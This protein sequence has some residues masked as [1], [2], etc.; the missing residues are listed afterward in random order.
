MK[1]LPLPFP[2]EVCEISLTK[3][4]TAIVSAEDYEWCLQ[5]KWMASDHNGLDYACRGMRNNGENRKIRLHRAIMER[6]VGRPLTP[7]ERIDHADRNTLNNSRSNLRFCTQAQNLANTAKRR[8]NTSGYKGVTR[9]RNGWRAQIRADGVPRHLGT[10][11]TPEE[12]YAA[13]CKAAR[14]QFGEF[15]RFE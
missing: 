8:A 10:F 1:Q 5:W 2:G 7:D 14:E 4:R 15:A 9:A 6:I 13:Y 11:D 12:A 3:G